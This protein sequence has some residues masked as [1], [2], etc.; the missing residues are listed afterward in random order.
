MY[1]HL[2]THTHQ[3]T[4]I[5]GKKTETMKGKCDILGYACISIELIT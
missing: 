1:R 3:S 5:I 4:R 2:L